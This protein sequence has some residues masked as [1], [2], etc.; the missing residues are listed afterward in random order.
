MVADEPIWLEIKGP[1]GTYW[2]IIRRPQVEK[3]VQWIFGMSEEEFEEEKRG[4]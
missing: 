4:R 2:L 3:L 1:D